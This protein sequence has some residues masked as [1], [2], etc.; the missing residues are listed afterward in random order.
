[1]FSNQNSITKY[2]NE[3]SER[4]S[5]VYGQGLQV[6]LGIHLS[7]N[8]MIRPRFRTC[9]GTPN[10][11]TRLPRSWHMLLTWKQQT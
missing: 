4:F 2:K 3:F 10:L 5:Q 8:H 9:L 1:M 7:G 6:F 11:S